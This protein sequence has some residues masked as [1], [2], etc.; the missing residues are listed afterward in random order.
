MAGEEGV[1][2]DLQVQ[3]GSRR[4]RRGQFHRR[5]HR[6][7]RVEPE[8]ALAGEW[9]VSQLTRLSGS[10]LL[11]GRPSVAL[12]NMNAIASMEGD[13][14]AAISLYET[15]R[16]PIVQKLLDAAS[17]SADWYE[18]LEQNMALPP[19]EF[20]HEYISRSGRVDRDRLASSCSA[21]VRQHLNWRY[22]AR[23]TSREPRAS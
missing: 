14:P 18:H 16:K 7:A 2:E 22:G 12:S 9:V 10:D 23:E 19:W 8:V 1:Y 5:H 20:A 4:Y 17:R 21:F 15:Q 3:L 13:I 11:S 6:Q